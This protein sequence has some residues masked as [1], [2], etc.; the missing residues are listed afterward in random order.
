MMSIQSA[1]AK[2]LLNLYKYVQGS[3]EL[4]FSVGHPA[5]GKPKPLILVSRAM[6]SL[7]S[8]SGFIS[9]DLSGASLLVPGQ[10]ALHQ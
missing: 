2:H 9:A 8:D 4:Q 5:A 7:Q 3:V 6:M 1:Q 10:V